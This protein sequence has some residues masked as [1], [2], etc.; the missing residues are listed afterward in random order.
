MVGARK[1]ISLPSLRWPLGKPGVETRQRRALESHAVSRKRCGLKPAP[2]TSLLTVLEPSQLRTQSQAAVGP[3]I[4][5]AGV[6]FF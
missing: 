3:F 5:G 4:R 1:E 2:P 6:F